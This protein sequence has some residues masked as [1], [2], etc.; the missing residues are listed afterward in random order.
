MTLEQLRYFVETAHTLHYTKAAEQLNISHP[1]SV[2]PFRS[3]ARDW[4]YR[5]LKRKE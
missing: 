3:Y 1:A 4:V 2:M 5:C